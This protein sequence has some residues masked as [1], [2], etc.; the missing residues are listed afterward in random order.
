MADG[1]MDI[2]RHEVSELR[3]VGVR[4]MARFSYKELLASARRTGMS[5]V[6][7]GCR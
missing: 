5:R 4:C 6:E 2:G 7:L 3:I 1:R